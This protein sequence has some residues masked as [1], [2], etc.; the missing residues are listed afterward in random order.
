MSSEQN[1]RKI[2]AKYAS[3]CGD[4]GYDIAEGDTILWAKGEPVTHAKCPDPEGDA[5]RRHFANLEDVNVIRWGETP[6]DPYDD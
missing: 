6:P 5:E 4:C 3:V 1:R 2:T